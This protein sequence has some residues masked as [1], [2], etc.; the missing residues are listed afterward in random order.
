[1]QSM[2]PILTNCP[3]PI[4]ISACNYIL[5][6][7]VCTKDQI[8]PLF[9]RCCTFFQWVQVLFPLHSASWNRSGCNLLESSPPLAPN[10]NFGCDSFV[11][12][13]MAGPPSGDYGHCETDLMVLTFKD[14][15]ALRRSNKDQR[16]SFQAVDSS[17]LLQLI[18]SGPPRKET[19]KK[20]NK[21]I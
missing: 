1:M 2:L 5:K 15:L 12:F 14:E 13:G 11:L 7:G 21:Y 18:K 8:V 9:S 20:R 4:F 6:E 17:A 16:L 3:Q 10:G 19:D